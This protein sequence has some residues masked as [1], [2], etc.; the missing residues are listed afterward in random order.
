MLASDELSGSLNGGVYSMTSAR[1]GA[2]PKAEQA[3]KAKRSGRAAV[4]TPTTICY[5]RNDERWLKAPTA[6]G[7][8]ASLKGIAKRK[9]FP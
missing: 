3:V 2:C 7:L 4:T 9:L 6:P 5:P 8:F 1:F